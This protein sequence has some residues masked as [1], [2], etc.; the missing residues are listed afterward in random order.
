[1][2]QRIQI[3]GVTGTAARLGWHAVFYAACLIPIVALTSG[4]MARHRGAVPALLLLLTV[5]LRFPFWFHSIINA[6]EGAMILMAQ[7]L[8]G[9]HLPFTSLW[10]IKPPGTIAA[11]SVLVALG[12][13]VV[14]VRIGGALLLFL[15]AWLLATR[16]AGRGSAWAAIL[17]LIFVSTAP[18]GQATMSEH[19][20][21][22]PLAAML[23]IA[24]ADSYRRRD[25]MALGLLL[26]ITV[27]IR[28]NLVFLA[29]AV[30]GAVV[31][32][33][34]RPL[35]AAA[36]LLAAASAPIAVLVIVY[37]AAGQLDALMFGVLRVPFTIP[38]VSLVGMPFVVD[39]LLLEIA[40]QT[41]SEVGL[42]WVAAAAAMVIAWRRRAGA[43]I[44]DA[45]LCVAFLGCTFVSIL[46]MSVGEARYL[47]QATPFL[48]WL[49]AA[50]I[51]R[52]L[53]HAR[54]WAW[55]I[56]AAL[57]LPLLATPGHYVDL[58]SQ[59]RRGDG[60]LAD[61]GHQLA[62]YLRDQGARGRLVY[63]LNESNV[64]AWMAGA[65]P[66]ERFADAD[67]PNYESIVR[68]FAGPQ[69]TTESE[70]LYGF[71]RVPDFVVLSPDTLLPGPVW[72]LIERDYRR[73]AII[74]RHIVY[75]RA[76]PAPTAR[77]SATHC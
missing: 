38:T 17:L 50:A 74:G 20:V 5:L 18:A 52:A 12:R 65:C 45:W 41:F 58:A 30:I 3:S 7:D 2:W 57:I 75:R 59:L 60:L 43:R 35:A 46:A 23:V 64:S 56:G 31:M 63:T 34:P 29:P 48:A 66:A 15:S 1:L 36:L 37:A 69:A 4:N 73:T 16:P 54:A 76:V 70:L 22:V 33:A 8:L 71:T 72:Q 21:M 14:T 49:G 51:D 67:Q 32:R 68:A 28:T 10:D 26:G 19:L 47:I 62:R 25:V 9:G 11:M 40:R 39:R 44:R 55:P 13:S 42:L 77:E 61:E 24:L 6:D 27:L 53:Q